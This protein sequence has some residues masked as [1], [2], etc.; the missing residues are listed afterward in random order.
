MKRKRNS[1]LVMCTK[2]LLMVSITGAMSIR[3]HKRMCPGADV[4][5]E[6]ATFNEAAVDDTTGILEDGVIYGLNEGNEPLVPPPRPS[7]NGTRYF[8]HITQFLRMGRCECSEQDLQLAKF[9]HMA[10]GG[11]GVSRTF[12][13]GMLAYAKD[14]GGR[15]FHLPDTWKTCVDHTKKLIED[16]EGKRK[17]FEMEVPIPQDVRDLL[18]DP[19]QETVHFEF[20]CP[21]TELVRVAMFSKTCKSWANVA[22]TYEENDGYL[23]DFCNGE[24]YKRI[25]GVLS[26]GSAILGAVL[27]T[28]GICL[29]KC[30]FDSQEVRPC[31]HTHNTMFAHQSG[32]GS[33][34][35]AGL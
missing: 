7:V 6:S 22:L 15:N 12:S 11:Y 23:D 9:V 28:D 26:P 19:S 5:P 3:N 27:A 13:E 21:V 35:G 14:S 4:R 32:L 24:R 18:A 17:T 30:M 16:L 33:G 8:S 10:H 2:C 1:H 34:L 20:E 29:D 25:A 31:L